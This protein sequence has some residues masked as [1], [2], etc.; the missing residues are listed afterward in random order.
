MKLSKKKCSDEKVPIQ[1]SSELF[2]SRKRLHQISLRYFQSMNIIQYKR[3]NLLAESGVNYL[4]SQK[5][6]AC[7]C[8]ESLA[9]KSA[10]DLIQAVMDTCR[11]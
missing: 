9:T 8:N 5:L 10:E 6:Y 11:K 7:S 2:T 1:V 4:T 3:A